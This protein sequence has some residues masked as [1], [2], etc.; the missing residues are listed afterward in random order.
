MR[1]VIQRVKN[2]SVAVECGPPLSIGEGLAVLFAASELDRE[3]YSDEL[4]RKLAHKTAN[5]RIFPD[6]DGKMNLSALQQGLSVMVVS[7]FTLYACT[8]KGNRPSFTAAAKPPFAKWVY[9]RYV[10]ELQCYEFKEFI[11]GEFGAKMTLHIVNDGPVTI[12]IDTKEW[13]KES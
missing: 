9:D 6:S 10:E 5:L 3:D 12:V 4:V 7:Q 13:E 1:V 8:K 11:T 2:A